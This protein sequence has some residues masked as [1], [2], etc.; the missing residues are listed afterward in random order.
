MP[1]GPNALKQEKSRG[2]CGGALE[3]A[4]RFNCGRNLIPPLGQLRQELNWNR[5]AILKG[6]A[7]RPRLTFGRLWTRGL[8]C[9]SPIDRCDRTADLR[10]IRQGADADPY[11]ARHLK[12]GG[13]DVERRS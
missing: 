13:C 4:C 7:R 1:N 11:G 3:N 8:F 12:S 2:Q 9:F 6:I 5:Q 10:L